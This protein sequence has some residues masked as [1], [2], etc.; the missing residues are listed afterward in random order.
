[1]QGEKQ[2]VRVAVASHV[3]LVALF[4]HALD[5]VLI[6]ND[7]GRFIGA[8]PAACVLLGYSAEELLSM[9]WV[10]LAPPEARAGSDGQWR[11]IPEA[12]TLAG[13]IQVHRKDG[14][15]LDLEFRAV[16]KL[17][18][19]AHVAFIRDVTETERAFRELTESRDRLREIWTRVLSSSEEQLRRLSREL[20]DQV[21]Q[22]LMAL[23]M[24]VHWLQ[25]HVPARETSAM[26]LADKLES[27]LRDI[28][29]AI[30][31]VRRLSASMRSNVLDRLGLVA[32]I[33]DYARDFERRSTIRCRV[34]AAMNTCRI[35]PAAA[36]E[37]FRI[38]E[39]ALANVA[40]HARANSVVVALVESERRL[41]LSVADNGVGI[42]A[43]A[44]TNG[45]SLGLIGMRERAVLLGG[46]LTV[47]RGAPS[48]TIVTATIPL[49]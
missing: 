44:I 37:A 8:N 9:R 18:P 25:E 34:E 14:T 33:R 11:G 13:R 29:D 1:M 40:E 15:L 6:A 23:K 3:D 2:M 45:R 38:F 16:V 26:A 35:S 49:S 10:D 31:V 39:Q 27:M 17:L 36:T 5:A 21:G 41:I 24:D 47:A 43:D 28:V 12:G 4:E 20:H 19:G 32:A 42:P 22:P 7:E 30:H 46:S 48:G